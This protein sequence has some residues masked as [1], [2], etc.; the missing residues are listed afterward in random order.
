MGATQPLAIPWLDAVKQGLRV[1]RQSII[2][3]RGW[4]CKAAAKDSFFPCLQAAER[5]GARSVIRAYSEP[6]Q[7]KSPI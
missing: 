3:W 1:R 6:L 2:G 4:D 7:P 5:S